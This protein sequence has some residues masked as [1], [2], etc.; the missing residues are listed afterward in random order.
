MDDDEVLRCARTDS[1]SATCSPSCRSRRSPRSRRARSRPAPTRNATTTTSGTLGSADITVQGK[2]AGFVEVHVFGGN[3]RVTSWAQ[4]AIH[5]RGHFNP[6]CH[7]DVVPSGDR[8]QIRL[9]CSHGPGTGDID[10][11]IPQA[12]SLEVRTMSADVSIRDVN[13]AVHTQ[14]VSGDVDLR[15]GSPSEIDL[16]STSG[17][18]TVES[19][20]TATRAHSISGDVHIAGVRGRATIRT[21][22]GECILSGGDFTGMEIETVSGDVVFQGAVT[23]Q[24]TFEVQ[25]H[26]GDVTLHL[27]ATTGAEVEMRST[28][29]D[30]VI[31]MGSGRKSAERELDARIGP[32]GARLRLR[33]FSGDVRVVR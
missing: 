26:S 10:V 13:G 33:S 29:G 17:D 32:G 3:V 9:A 7:I 25:S 14:T 4:N 27:P 18:V 1:S 11:Q 28:S 31:D 15:G 5:V 22:S 2:P 16:R 23:G 20:S 21:V 12:S 6:D 30:L 24:G 8:E 19:S